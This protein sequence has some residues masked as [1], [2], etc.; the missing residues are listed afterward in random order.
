MRI[1]LYMGAVWGFVW[2][3]VML[4]LM[5]LVDDFFIGIS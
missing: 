5:L 1:I 2:V 4:A 3:L